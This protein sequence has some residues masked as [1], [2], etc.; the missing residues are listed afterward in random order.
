IAVYLIRHSRSGAVIR[1]TIDAVSL[2]FL[3]CFPFSK[4]L[5]EL[6]A[7]QITAL[8]SGVSFEYARHQGLSQ[9]S[10]IGSTG[11]CATTSIDESRHGTWM[12]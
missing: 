9:L 3:S 8:M 7:R 12:L 5:A 11:S 1:A 4:A 10:A 6:Q 2:A